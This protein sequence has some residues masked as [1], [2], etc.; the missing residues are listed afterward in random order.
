MVSTLLFVGLG[1]PGNDYT[2][3]RHNVGFMIVDAF[4]RKHGWEWS[5]PTGLFQE[6]TKRYASRPVV[7]AKPL[8]YMN[9][10]GKAVKKLMAEHAVAPSQVIVIVD[11]YNFSSRIVRL[12][13]KGSDGGHNGIASIINELGTPNFWRMR[14]GIDRDFG[15]GGLVDYVLSPWPKEKEADRDAM[16]ASAVEAIEL[17]CKAGPERAMQQINSR[18]GDLEPPR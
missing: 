2:L 17:I 12:H 3:T 18:P 9:L 16:I 1:N 6:A 15:P 13:P 8:T 11:E 7:L 14:C 5:Q 10:S 4:V